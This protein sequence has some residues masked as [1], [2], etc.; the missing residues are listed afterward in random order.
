MAGLLRFIE[1][2]V[3]DNFVHEDVGGVTVIQPFDLQQ[4]QLFLPA[5]RTVLADRGG[6][7][8]AAC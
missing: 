5:L 4:L 6:A 8:H 7:A 3:C 1:H 2:D